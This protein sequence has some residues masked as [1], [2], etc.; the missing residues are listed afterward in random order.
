MQTPCDE[1]KLGK[2]LAAGFIAGLVGAW[3]MNQVQALLS[4]KIAGMERSHGAQSLR[5]G[6]PR[7]GVALELQKRG[8]DRDS[9]DAAMRAAQYLSE[10]VLDHDLDD[11]E[12][13]TGGVIAHYAMGAASGTLYGVMAEF[14]PG[15][16]MGGGLPFGAAVWMIA[17]QVVVP[18]AGLTKASTEYPL[19]EHGYSLISHLVYGLATELTRRAAR[20]VLDNAAARN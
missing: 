3:V 1:S 16:T 13:E 18:A 14:L 9:D 20:R 8:S 12:K 6:S 15:A 5:P 10:T 7:H 2:G 19:R 4:E 11:R 17:D